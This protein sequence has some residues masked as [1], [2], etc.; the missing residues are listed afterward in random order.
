MKKR[1]NSSRKQ[2]NCANVLNSSGVRK[3]DKPNDDH[4][5]D[6]MDELSAYEVLLFKK[7]VSNDIKSNSNEDIMMTNSS[8]KTE[9][10]EACKSLMERDRNI[11]ASTSPS[12]SAG[13]SDEEM[14]K[15]LG[16][17]E[18]N[19]SSKM[20]K[21]IHS[22]NVF[23][24][25]FMKYDSLEKVQD[26]P[27]QNMCDKTLQNSEKKEKKDAK[28]SSENTDEENK[29]VKNGKENEKGFQ[30][31]DEE[32]REEIVTDSICEEFVKC[33][34]TKESE[35]GHGP[36][37]DFEQK[38]FSAHYDS[39]Q[40]GL[41][42]IQWLI[43]P[44]DI[45]RFFRA[46]FQK[47]YSIFVVIIQVTT[48]IYLAQQ[49]LSTFCE[50]FNYIEYGTNV[51][52]A[53]YKNQQRSTLNGSGKA[54]CSIQFTNPQS[55]CDNV[56]YY[57]DLL[58][59][60]FGCFVGANTYITP[61]NT[62]GFAPHWD[63][64]D[65]FLLQL[66]GRKH[67]KIYA[68]I[69]D[70]EMLPDYLALKICKMMS[71]ICLD[72][73]TDDDVADRRPIFD[74]WL[75]Q[76]DLLYIPRGFIHKG[77]ADKNVHSLHLTISVCRNVTYADLLE[78]VI[79]PAL[80]N[81][82]EQHINIRKS[83]PAGY[84][85]MMGVLECDYPLFKTG[86]L[87]LDRFIDAI[88]AN[89]CNYIKGLIESAVDMMA[90]EFMRTALPPML[91]NEEKDMT[92]LRVVGSSLFDDKQ[93]IFTKNIP[94]KLLRRHGQRLI[95]ESEEHCFIVHRM[96]NSRVYEGRPEV[97]F[98]LDVKLAGGFANLMDIYPRWCLVSDLKCDTVDDSIRLAELLY[99]NGL[100]MAKFSE[101]ME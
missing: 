82:A 100:L 39:V 22:N 37:I 72:N 62:S 23:S 21:Q 46:V 27:R 55:F 98:D 97:L 12:K 86:A 92:A 58:Q 38:P 9:D 74:D 29:S 4:S 43:D 89:F 95:Y 5:T 35:N 94:I 71:Y 34:G 83:L 79:P 33:D 64:I 11:L 77:F 45:T 50:R 65:A 61:A 3:L 28:E 93:H 8:D 25:L 14:G 80:S 52:I 26:L 42:A 36:I 32:N 10:G 31:Y 87:K 84:L 78:R 81:F 44:Y 51:N 17:G 96:A 47:K 41:H 1:K 20:R 40:N 76:G 2:Q 67:W 66:E 13:K 85:D 75:E 57:C 7:S 101:A 24:S 60:V 73:F 69:N 59:E 6:S 91:T 63:D 53:V 68:P 19:G 88:F 70:S 16:K 90:R 49:N 18:L 54:G 56:W 48:A 15:S 99:S 30:L